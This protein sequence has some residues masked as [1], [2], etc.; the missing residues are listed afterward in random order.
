MLSDSLRVC[1]ISEHCFYTELAHPVVEKRKR[2]SVECVGGNDFIAAHNRGPQRSGDCA[3]AGGG[4]Q[5]SFA[6][7]QRG[8]LLFRSVD[9]RVGKTSIN[10]A[11]FLACKASAALL[12]R[13]KFK[14]GSLVDWCGKG[15]GG[16]FMLAYM[17]LP[18]RKSA[19]V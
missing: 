16:V 17:N 11:R 15:A 12:N 19:L 6:A 1:K 9:S 14:G 4:A 10:V 18:G 13:I 5:S 8:N 2:A 7:L 3:H